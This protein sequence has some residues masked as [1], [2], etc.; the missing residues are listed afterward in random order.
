M[1]QVSILLI[2]TV[3]GFC[4]RISAQGDSDT[5]IQSTIT[6][7]EQSWSD[8]LKTRDIK[9]IDAILD[10]R[11]L[12][13]NDDGSVQTK[14]DF[15][16]GVKQNFSLPTAQQLQ[17]VSFSL[18]IKMF[19]RTAVAIGDMRVKGVEHGKPYLRRDRF[20]DTWKYH[21]GA[22]TIIGTQATPVLRERSN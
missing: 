19:G 17:I 13:V 6:A 14:A 21:N 5:A 10:N 18:S 11:V 22:W 9:A 20:L 12:L 4:G 3:C 2:A 1:R 16:A 7:L 8:A 15:L